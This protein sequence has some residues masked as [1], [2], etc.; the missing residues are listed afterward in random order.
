MKIFAGT[1][2]SVIL[3][4]IAFIHIY[5][6]FGGKKWTD[7]VI[8][9]L[10]NDPADRVLTPPAVLTFLVAVLLTAAAYLVSSYAYE[11]PLFTFNEYADYF[12]YFLA[13]V[14]LLR[15][16]GD[17]KYAG[18]TKTVKNSDFAYYDTRVYSPLCL[19]LGALLLV[20]ICL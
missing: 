13:G 2:V 14:F 15:A 9:K 3:I 6:T 16:F 10:E 19:S 17:F 7:I 1:I 8:P 12:M 18:F 20:E 11:I 4:M 5:W